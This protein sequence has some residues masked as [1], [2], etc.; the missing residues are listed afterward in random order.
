[1]VPTERLNPMDVSLKFKQ[2]CRNFPIYQ[3][4]ETTLEEMEERAKRFISG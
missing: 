1:L 4:E 3:V 2:F